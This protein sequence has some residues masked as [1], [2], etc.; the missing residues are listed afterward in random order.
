M[1]RGFDSMVLLLRDVCAGV[2]LHPECSVIRCRSRRLHHP[3]P[4]FVYK[5]EREKNFQ[6]SA[7]HN[8]VSYKTLVQSPY[9]AGF[10]GPTAFDVPRLAAAIAPANSVSST[11]ILVLL[12]LLL[13]IP[14][15]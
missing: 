1:L 3:L 9:A 13:L 10:F 11:S 7:S 14:W 4:S 8:L 12:L 2:P 5:R 15:L 6:F